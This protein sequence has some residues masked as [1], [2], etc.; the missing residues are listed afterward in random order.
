MNNKVHA[1][2][3]GDQSQPQMDKIIVILESLTGQIQEAGYAPKTNFAVYNVQEEEKENMLCYHSDKLDIA[4]GL[5]ITCSYIPLMIIK[6]LVVCGDCHITIKFISKIVE[7]EIVV[8]DVSYFHCF[9]DG[10]CSSGN[11]W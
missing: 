9:K 1:F 11:Y 5:I 10:V 6:K 8:R 2:T 7:L 3:V 4:F